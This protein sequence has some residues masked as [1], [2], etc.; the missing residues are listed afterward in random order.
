MEIP[1]RTV[2]DYLVASG[3]VAIAVLRRQDHTHEFRA[4]RDLGKLAMSGAA[5]VSV[6][7]IAG[8]S[9]ATRVLRDA[10]KI[11]GTAA[12]E[13]SALAAL[14][15]AARLQDVHMTPHGIV[16]ERASR[17]AGRVDDMLRSPAMQTRLRLFNQEYKSRRLFALSRG[18][19]FITYVAACR[20]LRQAL[21]R[22]L[23]TAGTVEVREIFDE[24]FA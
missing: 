11:A 20:R 4:V 7:W 19:G 1:S 21:I 13:V 16:I 12:D 22:R 2:N 9:A 8:P 15:S 14:G 24:V 23:V 6:Q 17:A 3:V 18:Q 5:I 10:R